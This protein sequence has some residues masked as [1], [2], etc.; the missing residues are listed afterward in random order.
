MVSCLTK[1]FLKEPEEVNESDN[2]L[3]NAEAE[4]GTG[5][6]NDTSEE[7]DEDKD[8]QHKNKRRK[9]QR[10]GTKTKYQRRIVQN[11]PTTS[12][13]QVTPRPPL[14]RS[15]FMSEEELVRQSS[16]FSGVL[17]SNN[18]DETLKVRRPLLE[19]KRGSKISL[20][21]PTMIERS[22]ENEV[23]GHTHRKVF[24][25]TLETKGLG[26]D[27]SAKA[28]RFGFSVEA[29]Y[30]YDSSNVKRQNSESHSKA[31]S[32]S[33]FTSSC[34][35][36]KRFTLSK[37]CISFSQD[38]LDELI[39]IQNLL[40]EREI[41]KAQTA[42]KS[43]FEHFGTHVYL[44]E[45]H[46]GGICIIET[47][48]EGSNVRNKQEIKEMVESSHTGHVNASFNAIGKIKIEGRASGH[49][50]LSLGK[51]KGK[52]W[53]STKKSMK[54]ECIKIGGPPGVDD[55]Q[56]W[57]KGLVNDS[58]TWCVISGG[59]LNQE[60]YTGV[61]DLVTLLPEG[62]SDSKNLSAF[63]KK[64][65]I[66]GSFDQCQEFQISIDNLFEQFSSDTIS[67]VEAIEKIESLLSVQLSHEFLTNM[68]QKSAKISTILNHAT[69]ETFSE[70]ERKQCV[71]AM[72]NILKTLKGIGFENVEDITAWVVD[73]T[74]KSNLAKEMPL[75]KDLQTWVENVD[76][77]CGELE[78]LAFKTT[79]SPQFLSN[80]LAKS[81]SSTIAHFIDKKRYE[82]II[83][84]YALLI[85]L[86]YNLKEKAFDTLVTIK[87]ARG[88]V[89]SGTKAIKSFSQHHTN[90]NKRY[91]AV[92]QHMLQN[93]SARNNNEE[94]WREYL[95]ILQSI[96][97]PKTIRDIL[98]NAKNCSNALQRIKGQLRVGFKS[99][100]DDTL[101]WAFFEN[102]NEEL[103]PTLK[104]KKETCASTQLSPSKYLDQILKV[105]RLKEYYPDK[106]SLQMVQKKSTR[107]EETAKE[108]SDVPWTILTQAITC[109][110]TFRE[111][112]LETFKSMHS[113]NVTPG[114]FDNLEDLIEHQNTDTQESGSHSISTVSPA[115]L[116]LAIFLCCNLELRK[117]LAE[118]MQQ[119]KYAIPFLYKSDSQQTLELSLWP[120]REISIANDTMPVA[121][122][123]IHI[124]SFVRI[125]DVNFP[126]SKSKQ[127]NA[128]LRGQNEEYSTFSH[129]DCASGS[130]KRKIANGMIEV[131]WFDPV[132]DQCDERNPNDDNDLTVFAK[133][134]CAIFNLRGDASACKQQLTYLCH[135]SSVLV[136]MV[137]ANVLVDKQ[138]ANTWKTVYT[139][140]QDIFV[141]T[142]LNT[143]DIKKMESTIQNHKRQ[144]LASSKSVETRKVQFL[145]IYQS[146]EER[147]S[148]N[149]E[150][151][152]KLNTKIAQ[153]LDDT[154]IK[155]QLGVVPECLKL[156][157]VVDENA[158]E[159]VLGK[160]LANEVVS[161]LEQANFDK[162]AI[163]PLQGNNYWQKLCKA[164]KDIH[165]SQNKNII[166]Y[167]SF[168][169]KSLTIRQRQV[170]ACNQASNAMAVFVKA[171]CRCC[172]DSRALYYFLTS[173]GQKIN[174]ESKTKMQEKKMEIRKLSE[175]YQATLDQTIK[176][177]MRESEQ[178]LNDISFGLEHL[179]REMGQIYEAFSISELQNV[180]MSKNTREVIAFLP[181]AAAKSLFSGQAL[182]VMD[183]DA[184]NVQKRWIRAV[185]KELQK[186]VGNKKIS[187]MSILGIQSSG[188]S[189]V[190]NTMFGLKFSVSA[191]RCTKGIYVQL[192]PVESNPAN[193]SSDYILILDTE[194]LQSSEV[195]SGSG[196]RHDNEL[197]TL[198]VGLADIIVINIKGETIADLENILQIVT[199]AF[200]RFMQKDGN[201]E[202]PQT[203]L[204]VHQNVSATDAKIQLDQGNRQLVERLDRI[205][206]EVAS[207]E[208]VSNI[209]S[210]NHVLKFNH[211]K[212]VKY[213]PDL[214]L[215][216]PPMSPI[217][218]HYSKDVSKLKTD[219]M[220][221]NHSKRIARTFSHFSNRIAL[222]WNRIVSESL[223]FGFMNCLEIKANLQLDEQWQKEVSKFENEIFKW[224]NDHVRQKFSKCDKNF[225]EVTTS[226]IID[227]GQLARSK[228][229]KSVTKLEDFIDAS[230]FHEQMIDSK[231]NKLQ[232]LKRATEKI[233]FEFEAKIAKEEQRW[234]SDS[235][236]ERLFEEKK[237]ELKTRAKQVAEELHQSKTKEK[238]IDEE[239]INKKFEEMWTVWFHSLKDTEAD[240][241][242]FETRKQE[243]IVQMQTVIAEKY[244]SDNFR[245]EICEFY[246]NQCH[247]SVLVGSWDEQMKQ[248]VIIDSR[249]LWG[250]VS[251]RFKK[252]N[253]KPR[254]GTLFQELD[255]FFERIKEL[256]IAPSGTEFRKIVDITKGMFDD[257]ASL[258]EEL[259]YTFDKK[260]EASTSR[261]IYRFAL[262]RFSELNQRYQTKHSL[263]TKFL[264]YKPEAKKL[265]RVM[266]KSNSEEIVAAA[267]ISEK[268]EEIV[269]E[270]L[271]SYVPDQ[272]IRF[273]QQNCSGK[274]NLILRILDE[275]AQ[276]HDFSQYMQYV[277]YPGSYAEK[278]LTQYAKE[279]FFCKQKENGESQ[280]CSFMTG[281]LVEIKSDVINCIASAAKG[282]STQCK[283]LEMW[284][285]HLKS[286]LEM[287][288]L[289][290]PNYS[291]G[292]VMQ[293]YKNMVISDIFLE[294]IRNHV[295]KFTEKLQ[296]K[297]KDIKD[298]DIVWRDGPP[299]EKLFESIWGCT[300]TCPLC[301]EPCQK[302][303]PAHYN[304]KT[305]CH[306]CIQH[307]PGGIRGLKWK[308]SRKIVV[309]SCNFEIQSN[310]E[311]SCGRW[312]KCSQDNCDIYHPYKKYKDYM[313]D[314]DIAP[315][316]D[317]ANCKYW[318]WFIAT[319]KEKLVT[320]Y[321]HKEPDIPDDW[322]KITKEEALNSL[323]E[324]YA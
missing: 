183:G 31:F 163:V 265:F 71:R 146:G 175:R 44:G 36:L 219:I 214:W 307:K 269:Q 222:L 5:S 314:W 155:R 202:L 92:L 132:Q 212:H 144:Y 50:K 243:M 110:G 187:T 12:G 70:T 117:V 4:V 119:C 128:L 143:K 104:G 195:G 141:L 277:T 287:K 86:R 30:S 106:I 203:V 231:E 53:E 324:F 205:T 34:I 201:I 78:V 221:I 149:I 58:A 206:E 100:K 242:T 72:Q 46:L 89:K 237:N 17:F 43:F 40:G 298:I 135:M 29:G 62:F 102:H 157:V 25:K 109:N 79:V 251:A 27:I 156:S 10:K 313:P 21:N 182:E 87:T 1:I 165:R 170:E 107:L 140:E 299:Y 290:V 258:K 124:L 179:F 24:L 26:V 47:R 246:S 264:D 69:S 275:L 65:A 271:N 211:L 19:P 51:H 38:A 67:Y 194:G 14:R 318:M 123:P 136:V 134:P 160:S 126:I 108:A 103:F 55:I 241:V 312:C 113:Q 252:P 270:R 127:I 2:A 96:P 137:D 8:E 122:Q 35:P 151:K 285:A 230:E 189:T 169:Q 232:S 80:A 168:Q 274:F 184:S 73:N 272:L 278:W 234:K 283:N 268:L 39:N 210:F 294:N 279:I 253:P 257:T 68:M 296:K 260:F 188:K 42:C 227:L 90:Q 295:P 85:P 22:F 37:R 249:N 209:K 82:E 233:T 292:Y 77:Y 263:H 120:L 280:Y 180:P 125:G 99:V 3:D 197:A 204:M 18:I 239:T 226:L 254:V 138:Y 322:E 256:D 321:G 190:L 88:L 48:Y 11:I 64:E 300:A 289:V 142:N 83:L 167:D 63:L 20:T 193:N 305:D 235:R 112:V 105:F 158:K 172:F 164:E 225:Q 224:Y 121:S 196:R 52:S 185:L 177:E 320:Y 303:D 159:C 216:R 291:F 162:K 150:M 261:H 323:R 60:E 84:L 273:V 223:V 245:N 293:E 213:I 208:R 238:D 309:E 152:A 76:D 13:I 54:M 310:S 81:I 93:I 218:P 45:I 131:T 191:G 174:T 267:V 161:C 207:Q 95:M 7:S 15:K 282:K 244:G 215:G 9:T 154:N 41:M 118:K 315:S 97:V 311:R 217:S 248:Q 148:N 316:P 281:K 284:C 304:G 286:Q 145:S 66:G 133:E 220:K 166:T 176:D 198:V 240:T 199:H 33:K 317:M 173:L 247:H 6:E 91:A 171:L 181:E 139:S 75:S 57:K 98:D 288:K 111:N 94:L 186:E 200:V 308:T 115:D 228:T 23:E 229:T 266:V 28:S 101:V 276:N 74:T 236:G 178:A 116:F 114:N 61:W 56:E 153:A 129:K 306:S 147:Y 255:S 301:G 16:C 32:Y 262:E 59:K 250:K 130:I 302:T 297:C 49:W 192:L 259:G 319:F